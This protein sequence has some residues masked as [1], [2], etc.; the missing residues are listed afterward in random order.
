V[1]I[2]LTKTAIGAA[3]IICDLGIDAQNVYCER[4]WKKQPRHHHGDLC[5]FDGS[6]TV[7]GS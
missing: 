7:G 1:G 2:V 4:P 6:V 3:N 5:T